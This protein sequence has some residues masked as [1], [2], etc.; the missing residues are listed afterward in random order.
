MILR[1]E[2]IYKYVNI[3]LNGA[4][5]FSSD[6]AV[7]GHEDNSIVRIVTHIHSDHIVGL[8]SSIRKLRYIAGTPQTLD[9]LIALGYR[10]PLPKRLELDYEQKIELNEKIVKLVKAEHIPGTAQVYVEFP[11]GVRVGYTSD[12][13]NPGSGTP[14]LKD[15]DI[16]VIEATY[17]RP[18]WTRS[19]KGE[20]EYLFVDI[21]KY[22]LSQGPVIIHAYHGKLQEAMRILRVAGI[23]A[24]FIA[25]RQTYRI[26][27]A[28]EKH[29]YRFG[30][31]IYDKSREA[32]EVMKSNWYVYFTHMNSYSTSTSRHKVSKIILTG[33]EFD[34]PY[35]RIN[36]HTW[37]VALSDHADF[38]QLLQYV[39]EA[40][41]KILVTDASR[42]GAPEIF[43]KEVTR[44]LGIPSIPLP[45][46]KPLDL[47]ITQYSIIDT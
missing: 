5:L 47:S 38:E 32:Q 19:F 22:L 15:L 31:V 28:L 34:Q 36:N 25:S 6:I 13:K 46:K 30:E 9:M 2:D 10:I 1:L 33:W 39:E 20:V 35:R 42:A 16:L 11:D 8:R 41:P 43:A 3:T 26:V 21:V 27:K 29:G 7:D 12:F 44:R 45:L 14:V 18:D 4:I 40:K 23:S 17:G 24:P 37:I